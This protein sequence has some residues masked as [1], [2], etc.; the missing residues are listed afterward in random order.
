MPGESIGI[1][2]DIKKYAIHDGPGI[3][4]TVFLKG[5]PLSC[6]WCHNPEGLSI[7]PELIYNNGRCIGCGECVEACPHNAIVLTHQG[8]IT[9]TMQCRHCGLCTD[10]C[11]AKAREFT[12]RRFTVQKLL[13]IIE[14]DVPF[15]DES[16]GGVTFSG[17]EPLLQVD[18]LIKILDE[19]GNLQ[20]HRAVDTSGFTDRDTISAVARRTEL[21][22]Y[23]IKLMDAIRHKKFTG[24]SN[25]KI[26]ENLEYLNSLGAHITIRFPLIPGINDDDENIIAICKFL[27]ELKSIQDVYILPYHD[28]QATKYAKLGRS[29]DREDIQ[30][31]SCV[32]LSRVARRFED[33]GLQI[34][35][36]G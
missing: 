11:P 18:F 26:L 29:Y 24:V 12:E 33:S 14:R 31:P 20:I 13:K 22:L 34:N 3:R 27:A 19:C 5:C 15:Y 9:D 21:F 16:G 17:G 23:D 1:I 6:R 36:G 10:I 25:K 4:T 2:F 8:V 28:F 32:Q 35:I 7:T 30:R